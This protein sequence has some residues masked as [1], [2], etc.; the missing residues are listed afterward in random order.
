MANIGI[1]YNITDYD[2]ILEGLKGALA[3]NNEDDNLRLLK[4]LIEAKRSGILYQNQFREN[5]NACEEQVRCVQPKNWEKK[6]DWQ[7]KIYIPLQAKTEEV[8]LSYMNDI[9]YSQGRNFECLTNNKQVDPICQPLA[10]LMDEIQQ[11]CQFS[12][13]NDFCVREGITLGTGFMKIIYTNNRQIKYQ[14]RSTYTVLIDPF[15]AHDLDRARYVIDVYEKDIDWLVEEARKG[16][17]LYDKNVIKQFLEDAKTQADQLLS[18]RASQATNTADGWK[19]LMSIKSIDGTQYI[20]V[21]LQLSVVDLSEYWVKVPME[22]GMYEDRVITVI[23]NKYIIRNEKNE[24]G[25]IPFQ[26]CRTKVR[27]Y[28]SYGRGYIDNTRPLQD[29]LN[30][31]V[32]LGFDSVKINSMDII[33]V[34]ESKVKD[35]NSIKYKPLAVWKMKD[36]SGVVLKRN[37]ASSIKDVMVGAQ[38]IDQIHQDATGVSR[39]AS[40]APNLAGSGDS[41]QT[42]GEYKLKL[43]MVDKRFLDQ[44]R[45]IENDYL[46]PLLN[47]TLQIILNPDLF[48]QSDVDEILGYDE[49]DEIEV[50][51]GMVKITEPKGKKVSRL[52]LA[53]LRDKHPH[54]NFYFRCVGAMKFGAISELIQKYGSVL[55]QALSNPILTKITNIDVLWRKFVQASG[56][57]EYDEVLVDEKDA[58]MILQQM[59]M[60]PPPM[61]PPQPGQGPQPNQQ[62]Q[63][64]QP[65]PGQ[66]PPVASPSGMVLTK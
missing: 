41:E 40:G 56:V 35:P 62:Q 20:F 51:N 28:D 54:Y 26:W 64:I 32:N 59:L 66:M 58:K 14:W 10:D 27:K 42:L 4:F 5:W 37:P 7:S 52:D 22:D 50:A 12:I 48:H 9:L 23:N 29:L 39:Q 57:Q 18:Q 6:E 60:A 61:S 8:A 53:D 1:E 25:F 31:C 47:K 13:Q 2:N 15:C 16:E 38:M 33:V 24:L 19:Q 45:F 30:A 36:V 11:R 55:T 43:Q 49:F 17:S 63:Q 65:K 34:D 3:S 44:A 46:E 21:P